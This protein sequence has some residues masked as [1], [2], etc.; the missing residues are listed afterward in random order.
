MQNLTTLPPFNDHFKDFLTVPNR[1]YTEAFWCV[2]A[3]CSRRRSPSVVFVP[4]Q[5]HPLRALQRVLDPGGGLGVAACHL[6]C[7]HGHPG[8]CDAAIGLHGQVQNS[9]GNT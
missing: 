4:A 2:S 5:A 7:H 8:H 6:L 1:G 9:E 3:L